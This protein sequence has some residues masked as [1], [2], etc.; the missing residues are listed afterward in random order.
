MLRVLGTTSEVLK[1]NYGINSP[2]P[3]S[4]CFT[5]FA[6]WNPSLTSAKSIT[7]YVRTWVMNG[8]NFWVKNE[9]PADF[10]RRQ[11]K[12]SLGMFFRILLLRRSWVRRTEVFREI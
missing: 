1:P 4:L 11:T 5:T 9:T 7:I 6:E 3:D 12:I 8:L 2:K 10:V